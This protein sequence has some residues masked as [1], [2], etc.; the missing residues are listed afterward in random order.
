MVTLR[1]EQPTSSQK[2]VKVS[3]SG[4]CRENGELRY[5]LLE[6]IISSDV[7][8]DRVIFEAPNRTLQQYFV[9]RLG[10]RVNLGNIAFGDVV[11]L[12]T[13]RL[14]LRFDTFMLFE[15]GIDA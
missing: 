3:T 9:K 7:E 14:G 4:I 12:E 11:S 1:L 2:R 13:L 8:V 5:G 15:G 6:E 10:H